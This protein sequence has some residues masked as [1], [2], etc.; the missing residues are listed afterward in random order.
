MRPTRYSILAFVTVAGCSGLIDGDTAPRPT[1]LAMSSDKILVGQPLD[2]YGGGFLNSTASGHSEVRFEGEFKA[3]S[4]KTYA[5]DQRIRTRWSDG[6]HIVWPFV[7]PYSNPF[8]P[9]GG[10]QTGK[11]VGKV[12]AVNV[13]GEY[14][15]AEGEA[16]SGGLDVELTFEP[17]IVVRD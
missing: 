6:N 17:G 3:D 10:E 4:G 5:V 2:F 8:T 14:D 16:E 7:G 1:L 15:Q 9:K 12:T 11:F 13:L